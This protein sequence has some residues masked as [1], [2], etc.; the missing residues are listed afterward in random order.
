MFFFLCVSAKNTDENFIAVLVL[1]LQ[2]GCRVYLCAPMTL[3]TVLAYPHVTP[4]LA[5][6]LL[7][8]PFTTDKRAPSIINDRIP[9][10]AVD[11]I[12]YDFFANLNYLSRFNVCVRLNKV[13]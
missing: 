4:C 3:A 12:I 11:N 7:S 1:D 13:A 6:E 5:A 8:E 9:T 10:R 2:P